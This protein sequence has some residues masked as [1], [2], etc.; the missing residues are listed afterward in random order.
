RPVRRPA[1]DIPRRCRAAPEAALGQ[2]AP[3]PSEA[4]RRLLEVALAEF[5][6][7]Q[8]DAPVAVLEATVGRFVDELEALVELCV[9][10]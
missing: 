6:D 7:E 10:R 4:F 2:R 5:L 3:D 1:Q 8:P 9:D